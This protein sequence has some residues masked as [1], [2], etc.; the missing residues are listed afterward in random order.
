MQNSCLVVAVVLLTFLPSFTNPLP[1]AEAIEKPS[2]PITQEKPNVQMAILLDTSSSMSGLIN[3]ARSQLWKIVNQFANVQQKGQAP[4]LEVALY[5]YGNSGLPGTEG[6]IRMVVPLTDDLDQVSE[7]LFKLSTNGGSEFCGQVIQ[8]AVNEL[9]WSASADDLKCIFIAGNEPFTQGPVDYQKACQ[10]AIKQ[11]ITVSTIHC[12]DHAEGVNTKWAEGAQLADGSY[13]NI[14]QNQVVQGIPA[15]QDKQLSQLSAEL[16]TTYIAFGSAQK[17]QEAA[18][19]QQAQDANAG[20]LSSTSAAQRAITKASAN[21]RN[22]GWDLC[23]AYNLGKV[24][25]EDIPEDQLPASLKKLSLAKRK[26]YIQTMTGKRKAIQAKIKSLN[27]QREKFVAAERKKL[28]SQPD[29]TLDVAIINAVRQQAKQ[30]N[31]QF[32]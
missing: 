12:G 29:N 31:F 18:E 17:R 21:Y 16:N 10:A 32:K 23:D 26:E 24:K 13:M 15:P 30:K 4:H 11:G 28:A 6:F 25:L 20:S 7:E 3:Q 14:D 1:A 19:R 9:Q 8:S 2:V 27:E 5:E 22:H